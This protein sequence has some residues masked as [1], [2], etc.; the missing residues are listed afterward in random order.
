MKM[1]Q[2]LVGDRCVIEIDARVG[3]RSTV[4]FDG[5]TVNG[6]RRVTVSVAYDSRPYGTIEVDGRVCGQVE[7]EALAYLV[8][9]GWVAVV[10]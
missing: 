7:T 5:L 1:A 8:E 10:L 9:H 2:I 3:L 4:V 6:V